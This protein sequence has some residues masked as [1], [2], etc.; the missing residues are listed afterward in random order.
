MHK[1]PVYANAPVYTNGIGEELFKVGFC[2]PAGSYVTRRNLLDLSPVPGPTDRFLDPIPLITVG[3]LPLSLAVTKEFH[4]LCTHN[5]IS[6]SRQQSIYY[7][8]W[9]ES[10]K[11]KPENMESDDYRKLIELSKPWKKIWS[12]MKIQNKGSQYV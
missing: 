1:Q 8:F 4:I 11:K 10:A 7:S 9:P 5:G 6:I 3:F 2:L 12:M